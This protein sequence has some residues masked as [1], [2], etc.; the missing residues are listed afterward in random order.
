MAEGRTRGAG[1]I[2]RRVTL[3]GLAMPPRRRRPRGERPICWLETAV[4]GYSAP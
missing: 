4:L 1:S 2:V 3:C